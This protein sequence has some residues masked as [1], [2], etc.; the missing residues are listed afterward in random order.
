MSRPLFDSEYLYGVH[1]RGAEAI[2]RQKNVRGWVLVTEQVDGGARSYR[3]LSDEDFGVMVRLNHGYLGAGT[4][5]RRAEYGNFARRCADF[6]QRSAGAAIWIIGN[7]PNHQSEWPGGSFDL[8]EAMR[9]AEIIT[10]QNYA[11]CFRLARQAIHALP[12]HENDLVLPAA[13]APWNAALGDWVKYFKDMLAAIGPTNLDGITLHTYTHGHQKALITSDARCPSPG[14]THLRWEFRTYRDYMEAIPAEMRHLPVF[15]TEANPQRLSELD[16]AWENRNDGWV[17][18]AYQEIDLW[19]R[20]Q[21][22]TIRSLVLFRWQ[23]EPNQPWDI[24]SRDQVLDDFRQALDRGLKWPASASPVPIDLTALLK[25]LEA[26]EAAAKAILSASQTAATSAAAL[27]G[28]QTRVDGLLQPA[29]TLAG[30]QPE[31]DRLKEVVGKLRSPG[32]WQPVSPPPMQDLRQQLPTHATARFTTRSRADIRRLIIHHTGNVATPLQFAQSTIRQGK[33]GINYHFLIAPD[34]VIS[35]VQDLE[36]VV[37]ACTR[38]ENNIDSIALALV[39]D[40]NPAPPSTEQME[41]A[42]RLLAWLLTDLKLGAETVVGR[43]ELGETTAPSPGRQWLQGARYKEALLKLVN[44]Y[45]SPPP[46]SDEL[47][48]LRRQVAD[49][50]RQ[51]SDSQAEVGRLQD[52]LARCKGEVAPSR[53]NPPAMSDI[54]D[55]LPKK[56]D[57]APFPSQDPAA[58]TRIVIS[59]S[60]SDKSVLPE[61]IALAYIRSGWWGIGY[62]FV[63]TPDGTIFQTQRLTTALNQLFNNQGF[64]TVEVCL[65]GYFMRLKN[66]VEQPREDQLPTAAQL[67]A[68]GSLLA[69]LRQELPRTT[70]NGI[71]GRKEVQPHAGPGE[72]W[73]TGANWKQTLLQQIEAARTTASR[74]RKPIEHYLLFWDHGGD[75]WAKADWRNAQA[76]IERFRPTTGFSVNDAMQA[77]HVTIVGGYGGV[78]Q[79]EGERLK[80]AGVILHRLA[81]ADE[82]GTRAMLD[83]LVAAGVRWPEEIAAGLGAMPAPD[84]DFGPETLS[85][86]DLIDVPK[87][88][89]RRSKP[90]PS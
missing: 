22:Q 23:Y 85:E 37:G 40:F 57:A 31:L 41:S 43:S 64:S 78:A 49:L 32:P 71:V 26:L 47:D 82:A 6:V 80:A 28:A 33:P 3:D 21:P 13:V 67:A 25:R 27:A 19:N 24:S 63:I 52:E 73:N 61:R 48:R 58:I 5:P 53:L 74:P 62:H 8:A 77:E 10:P 66:N 42:A 55:S 44:D 16:P 38:P 36:T 88:P 89:R 9:Q 59:H 76:Y 79:T 12:G 51:L 46:I 54:V 65:V 81:G 45:L 75:A 72:E 34:G 20:E 56:P 1:D 86:P 18:A 60:G 87:R 29:R 11:E 90:R 84:L 4:I 83:Q 15:I 17:D 39:G 68:A 2:M 35:W 7:E 50:E 70:D 14:F 30:W 69:W